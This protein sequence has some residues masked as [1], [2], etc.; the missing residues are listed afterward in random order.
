MTS[1]IT[2]CALLGDGRVLVAGGYH[3]MGQP[4]PSDLS[5]AEVTIGQDK[6]P[7][8][9]NILSLSIF[10]RGDH[11]ANFSLS[12]RYLTWTQCLGARL[13]VFPREWMEM[14]FCRLREV[15]GPARFL[16]NRNQNENVT[17]I[18]R[19][20]TSAVT[21]QI[22]SLGATWSTSLVFSGHN[23][24]PHIDAQVVKKL[25]KTTF[26]ITVRYTPD[27]TWEEVYQM[28][29]PR[30]HFVAIPLPLHCEQI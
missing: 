14:L 27:G 12:C 29:H 16:L 26:M 7:N 10:C 17:H 5:T 2:S 3:G 24:H 18:P 20:C 13:E 28:E 9:C 25:C 15:H 4:D 8:W 22:Q 19:C 11:C 21:D 6:G 23:Q 1:Y 30:A